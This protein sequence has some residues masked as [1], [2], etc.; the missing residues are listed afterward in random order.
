MKHQILN[1]IDTVDEFRMNERIRNKIY[2]CQYIFVE[3]V[4]IDS[5]S[6]GIA[7]VC[8]LLPDLS[9]FFPILL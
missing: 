9:Q 1:F 3:D 2:L 8:P 4:A 6:H 5:T 7:R